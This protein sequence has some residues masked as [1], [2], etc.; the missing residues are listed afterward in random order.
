[1]YKFSNEQVLSILFWIIIFIFSTFLFGAS[2][3][4]APSFILYVIA[5]FI[6]FINLILTFIEKKIY[7]FSPIRQLSYTTLFYCV[8]IGLFYFSKFNIIPFFTIPTNDELLLTNITFIYLC[9]C[10]FL[11]LPYIVMK[12]FNIKVSVNINFIKRNFTVKNIKFA[13][14]TITLVLTILLI[15]IF[16][17]TNYNPISAL[18]NPLDFRFEY[19]HGI[20]SYVFTIF[21]VLLYLNCFLLF[22]EYCIHKN[23]HKLNIRVTGG[24][25]LLYVFWL[26]VSGGRSYIIAPAIYSI[27]FLSFSPKIKINLKTLMS[28]LLILLISIFV[29][30]AY[31]T[32]RNY[33]QA[34]VTNNFMLL[35]N[36]QFNPILDS[37]KR[38]DNFSNSVIFFKYIDSKYG[39]LYCYDDFKFSRQISSQILNPIPREI[40]PTKGYPVSGE[41]TKLLFPDAFNAKINLIFGGIVNLFYTGG[42][43]FVI[44]DALIM[45]FLISIIE[46]TYKKYVYYDFFIVNYIA[47]ILQIPIYY[48][49]IGFLNTA[50]TIPFCLKSFFIIVIT[51]LLTRIR[52]VKLI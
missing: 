18:I 6:I 52:K 23:E 36:I 28:I 21:D 20:A 32:Y 25:V 30:M 13:I 29:A 34:V 48:F 40:I 38:I 47:C 26:V 7:F 51:Y 11:F 17:L 10:L 35:T 3:H 33:R 42:F 16:V 8:L 22:N 45:G 49:S 24:F 44:I 27:Y 39:S 9:F 15:L 46:L 14:Q 2:L 41:L 31:F 50:I 43:V 12:I 1:M 5:L 37:I 19:K 4:V